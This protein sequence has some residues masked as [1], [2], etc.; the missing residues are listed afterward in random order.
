MKT[1][2]VTNKRWKDCYLFVTIRRLFVTSYAKFVAV[3][4]LFLLAGLFL[5][6]VAAQAFE[7]PDVILG[8]PAD[9]L[10][11]LTQTANTAPSQNPFDATKAL[12][13]C[14]TLTHP[15]DAVD[16]EGK[17]IGGTISNPCG[18][19]DLIK[20][21]NNVANYLIILG[22]SVAT[23]AFAYAGFLMM[24]AAGEMSKIEKA[25]SIFGKVLVGFLLMLAA[26][27]IVHAIESAFVTN[28]EFK[29]LLEG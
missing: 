25:K 1:G 10:K 21:V 22:A 7:E 12:V 6:P 11:I 19:N 3:S 14:G 20:L 16:S 24:T 13:P 2:I 26:W 4:V 5:V 17:P 8:K 23:I 27:L 15:E 29:S 28:T 9:N 18:W